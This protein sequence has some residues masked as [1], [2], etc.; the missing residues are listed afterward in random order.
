[1]FYV[2]DV[3]ETLK[4][5]P[6]ESVHCC[7][8]SPAYW[9]LRDYGVEG[10]LGLEPVPD[11][12]G[13]V[14]GQPCGECYVCH[15]VQV[16]REVK[17]VL[18]KDGQVWLNLGDSYANTFAS[19]QNNVSRAEKRIP[20]WLKPKDLCGIPWRVAFALQ[21]DGWYLRSDIIW[22]KVNAMP[23]S[24][25]DR[26][27]HAHEYLFLL[28]KSKHYF[29]DADAIREPRTEIDRRFG[30]NG[31][32]YATGVRYHNNAPKGIQRGVWLGQHPLG[33][34]K[35]SVWIIPTQPFSEA[36]FATFPPAL[37]EPCIKAGTS[38][39]GCC[40]KCGAPW[41]RIVEYKRPPDATP[42]KATEAWNAGT[43]LSPHK[44]YRGTPIVD[45]KGW[46]PTCSCGIEETVPCVVLDPFGG[47]GT[48]SMVAKQLGRASIYIDLNPTY[49]GMAI[50]RC[51]FSQ[52]G[53]FEQ[54][55][56][57]VIEGGVA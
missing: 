46:R 35:R 49:V 53:L 16:F 34:N 39:Y 48:V 57:E 19:G 14:T 43:G 44:G 8:T 42:K 32:H 23:E 56:Y 9:G 1:M 2:G 24:V 12:F 52:Q 37:V 15:V 41:K 26:P 33:H 54:H 5:L 20:S 7:V 30:G 28:T 36:H 21:A 11:C 25:T 50:K 10:Q 40:P 6:S 31:T 27:T 45:F 47:S 17:R 18:R 55:T 29:Y 13:W 38:E 22:A 51:G 4:K 3:L